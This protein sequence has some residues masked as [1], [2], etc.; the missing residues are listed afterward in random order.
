MIQLHKKRDI[1]MPQIIKLLD[2]NLN[3]LKHELIDDMLYI[4][5]EATRTEVIC[6]F[7]YIIFKKHSTY[8]RSFQDLSIQGKKLK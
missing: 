1:S 5:V 7:W 3:Y 4:F 2:P 8:N 6:P